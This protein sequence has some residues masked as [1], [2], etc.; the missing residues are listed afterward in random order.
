M[1]YEFPVKAGPLGLRKN[2]LELAWS[3]L[4]PLKG[5]YF[6]MKMFCRVRPTVANW[7][8]ADNWKGTADGPFLFQFTLAEVRRVPI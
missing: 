6:C 1:S 8:L 4:P 7:K 2:A 5:D 3:S